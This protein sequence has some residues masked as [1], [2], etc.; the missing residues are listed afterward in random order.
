MVFHKYKLIFTGIAKN[1]STSV[2]E[3]LR[4]NTDNQHNHHT[5]LEDY[6]MNDSDLME[7]YPNF[8]IVR[9]PYDRFISGCHQIRRDGESQANLSINEI[10]EGW[11]LKSDW[12][13]DA[14]KPQH[15]FVCFG[16][17]I[18]MDHILRYETLEED[19]KKFVEE[20][21][22]NSKFKIRSKLPSYNVSDDKQSWKEELKELTEDNLQAL[23]H[24]YE[25]DFKL[26][27]Y[28]IINKL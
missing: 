19:W 2:F 1:A 18:L 28:E 5:I 16:N 24:F 8:C 20:Y 21:N 27:N 11:V 14:F 6:G 13:N 4:N 9:N 3:V 23:N 7:S 26:F 12:L 22:K 17:N 15:R 25:K 10:F